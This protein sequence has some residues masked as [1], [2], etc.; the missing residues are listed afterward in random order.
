MVVD[1][2]DSCADILMDRPVGKMKA[3]ASKGFSGSDTVSVED[4][5]AK[6][7]K[8]VSSIETIIADSH[9]VKR[10]A[11]LHKI[12]L[13]DKK[14]WGDKAERL[15]GPSSSASQEDRDLAER[16]IRKHV[17]SYRM[18]M[19]GELT[20]QSFV[21]M[22]TMRTMK[23]RILS[24]PP[25]VMEM[26]PT[27]IYLRLCDNKIIIAKSFELF[28]AARD[29]ATQRRA[30]RRARRGGEGLFFYSHTK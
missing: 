13:E 11:E 16:L 9:N 20:V 29:G 5:T 28:L 25:L 17:L 6:M 14:F 10:A 23:K 2:G 26:I 21:K 4:S 27:S 30:K 3:K 24:H 1:D 7:A 18:R 15:F 22:K 12:A 19:S 8:Y